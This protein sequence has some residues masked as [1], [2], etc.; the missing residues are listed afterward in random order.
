MPHFFEKGRK[1]APETTDKHTLPHT[2]ALHAVVHILMFMLN[3]L[4]ELLLRH[5]QFV[6]YTGMVEY[7]AM[8]LNIHTHMRTQI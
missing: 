6:T 3:D 1:H 5:V 2:G 8:W 4:S 7:S